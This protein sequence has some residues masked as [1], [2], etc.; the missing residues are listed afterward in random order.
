MQCFGTYESQNGDVYDLDDFTWN[1]ATTSDWV[2]THIH[3][4]TCAT[5]ET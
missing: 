3:L 2:C 1:I 4:Q 5:D